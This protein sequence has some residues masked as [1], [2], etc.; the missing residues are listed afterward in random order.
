MHKR[1]C[2]ILLLLLVG[3][4]LDRLDSVTPVL[5]ARGNITVDRTSTVVRQNLVISS[6]DEWN[7]LQSKIAVATARMAF[8][9]LENSID[10]TQYTVLACFDIQRNSGGYFV[11]VDI[12]ENTKTLYVNVTYNDPG[13]DMLTPQVI[14]QPYLIVKIPKTSKN[15]VFSE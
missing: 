13:S 8:V 1:Y 6:A 12:V 7:A 3:C 11:S 5:I 4:S 14:C 9:S 2:V 15:I 10:F